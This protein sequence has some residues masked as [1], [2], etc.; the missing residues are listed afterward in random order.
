MLSWS[1]HVLIHKWANKRISICKK[2]NFMI[3][4]S[5]GLLK[6]QTFA[7]G[8]R[9]NFF[10]WYESKKPSGDQIR[11][12]VATGFGRFLM[13]SPSLKLLCLPLV[14][15]SSTCAMY[16]LV[17]NQRN[18]LIRCQWILS[19]LSRRAL[20]KSRIREILQYYSIWY[21]IFYFMFFFVSW[22]RH[23][24]RQPPNIAQYRGE[25]GDWLTF[26]SLSP[27]SLIF[28]RI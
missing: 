28:Q 3:I 16:L 24:R 5:S 2:N 13:K 9:A 6:I 19:I 27:H 1:Q 10:Y 25:W 23:A 20:S 4:W 18:E 15:G 8:E 17:L 7:P 12:M 21:L 26:C 11:E 14:V 22:F